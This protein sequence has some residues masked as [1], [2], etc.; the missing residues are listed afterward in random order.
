MEAIVLPTHHILDTDWGEPVNTFDRPILEHTMAS[1]SLIL[2]DELL[3]PYVMARVDFRSTFAHRER[4]D[5]SELAE[6]CAKL[7]IMGSFTPFACLA[8]LTNGDVSKLPYE[9]VHAVMGAL[10]VQQA[11]VERQGLIH[12]LLDL[13][14]VEEAREEIDDL[15]RVAGDIPSGR[16]LWLLANLDNPGVLTPERIAKVVRLDPI[17]AATR[18]LV[19]AAL[20]RQG[21]PR[22]ALAQLAVLKRMNDFTESDRQIEAALGTQLGEAQP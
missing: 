16:R 22:Q 12:R 17:S 20:L 6:R 21:Q 14:H 3:A 5:D 1:K 13:G 15:M 11:S 4:L 19:V 8:E 2:D 9:Y 18:R 7:R 10:R